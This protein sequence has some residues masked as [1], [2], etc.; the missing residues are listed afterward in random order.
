VP[1]YNR[2]RQAERYATVNKRREGKKV[3]TMKTFN[4]QHTQH[5][6]SKA[7]NAVI[8]EEYIDRKFF[9]AE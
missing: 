5:E 8:Y 9:P 4:E 3:Y 2:I 1:P 6:P 7:E